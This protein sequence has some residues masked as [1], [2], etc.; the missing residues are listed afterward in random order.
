MAVG[1]QRSGAQRRPQ[2]GPR[3]AALLHVRTAIA[4]VAVTTTHERSGDLKIHSRLAGLTAC[5]QRMG[6]GQ[7]LSAASCLTS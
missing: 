1:T 4:R 7:R 3:E 5:D 2:R 6:H